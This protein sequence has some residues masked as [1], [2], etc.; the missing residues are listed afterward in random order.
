MQLREFAT[1]RAAEGVFGVKRAKQLGWAIGAF[2]R[3]AGRSVDVAEL[4]DGLINQHLAWMEETPMRWGK[5]RSLETVEG[6]KRLLLALWRA[7]YDHEPPLVALPPKRVR[8]IRAPRVVVRTWTCDDVNRLAKAASKI[9]G[10]FDDTG[11]RRA[12]FWVAVIRIGWSTALRLGDYV[13]HPVESP[14]A[15]QFRDI[16]ED[17]RIVRVQ[18]KTGFE[19]TCRLHPSDVDALDETLPPYREACLPWLKGMT[20]FHKAFRA[21]RVSAG[22]SDGT[23]GDLRKAS[24]TAMEKAMPGTAPRHLGHAPGSTIA[25]RHYVDPTQLDSSKPMPPELAG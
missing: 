25:Y 14:W 16:A 6:R 23:I 2:E 12:S 17:G 11:I 18:H 13:W 8:K 3:W 10:Y 22:I 4:S 15:I 1:M 20:Y 24:S 19:S 5:K 9:P 21:I 7:A